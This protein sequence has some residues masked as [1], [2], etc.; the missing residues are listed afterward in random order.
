MSK[1]RCLIHIVFATKRREMTITEE[2]KK[3]LYAYVVG[4]IRNKQCYVYRINGIPDHLHLLIDLHPMVALANLVKDI[5]QF[6]NKWLRDNPEKFPFFDRWGEGYYAVSVSADDMEDCCKY[7]INQ[8]VHHRGCE[9]L[10]EMKE[11]ATRYGLSWY[12][13]DWI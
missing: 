13:D 4:I 1:T 7:I 5:K 12:E 2:Y 3:D 8:E 6:S 9:M 11:M 10:N